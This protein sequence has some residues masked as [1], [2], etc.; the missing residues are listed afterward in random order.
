M[1]RKLSKQVKKSLAA[2]SNIFA[3]RAETKSRNIFDELRCNVVVVA[4]LAAV[5]VVV[6]VVAVVAN[7][8]V[9]ATAANVVVLQ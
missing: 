7:V 2:K 6:A 4:D 3:K 8:A 5:V 9:V 1:G